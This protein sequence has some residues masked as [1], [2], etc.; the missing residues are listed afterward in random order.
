VNVSVSD[1]MLAVHRSFAS[2]VVTEGR[3][4]VPRDFGHRCVHGR[5]FPTL[6][7]GFSRTT[8]SN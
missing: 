6:L 4:V 5:Q 7:Q 2:G 8:E 3:G 1:G